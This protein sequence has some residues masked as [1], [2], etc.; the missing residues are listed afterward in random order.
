MSRARTILA[1]TKP[2]SCM[3]LWASCASPD[4]SFLRIPMCVVTAPAPPRAAA[5]AALPLAPRSVAV[6]IDL[7]HE[8]VV[9][10]VRPRRGVPGLE[11]EVPDH[12]GHVRLAAAGEPTQHHH[13]VRGA[14]AAALGIEERLRI[15]D[16]DRGARPLRGGGVG[17]G[18]GMG[19]GRGRG[20]GRLVGGGVGVALV[21]GVGRV[22]RLPRVPWVARMLLLPGGGRW[23]GWVRVSRGG[24]P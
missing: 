4:M 20:R 1:R 23:V 12:L 10:G 21:V 7:H 19:C 14:L 24:P 11:L 2:W 9:D 3:F 5:A 13:N 8:V 18:G 15:H 16:V 22:P 6:V 17:K